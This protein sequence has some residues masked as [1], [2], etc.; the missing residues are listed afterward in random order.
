MDRLK[1][2]AGE[3]VH[4]GGIPVELENTTT[5]LGRK[6]NFKAFENRLSG[7]WLIRIARW[8]KGQPSTGYRSDEHE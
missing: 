2:P 8:M 3:I 5:V 7:G 1:I 6:E 4:Y